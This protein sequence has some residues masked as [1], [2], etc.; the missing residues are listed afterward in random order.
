VLHNSILLLFFTIPHTL[1]DFATGEPGDAGVPAP[2]LSFFVSTIFSVQAVGLYWLGDKS[3]K[4]LWVHLGVGVFWPLASGIAQV[5]T[6]LAET[7]YR[8]GFISVAYVVGII[9]VGVWLFLLTLWTL[10]KEI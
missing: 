7:S 2:V 3:R 5:P 1:E 6:I 10:R 8:S 9:V 4:G